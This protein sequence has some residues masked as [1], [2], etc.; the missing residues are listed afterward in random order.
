ME[1]AWTE[2]HGHHEE[3]GDSGIEGAIDDSEHLGLAESADKS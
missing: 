2:Y 1:H 3:E